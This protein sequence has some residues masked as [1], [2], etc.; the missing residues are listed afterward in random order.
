MPPGSLFT[1]GPSECFD[2]SPSSCRL[3][4]TD[5]YNKQ[6]QNPNR[7][8]GHAETHDMQTVAAEQQEFPATSSLQ[9]KPDDT[10]YSPSAATNLI[11]LLVGI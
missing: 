5:R 10:M 1:G 11:P 3:P 4:P 8:G 9:N 2:K 6:A 7:Q